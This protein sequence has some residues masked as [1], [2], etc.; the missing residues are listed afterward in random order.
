MQLCST[1]SILWHCLSLG[2][3]WKLIFSSPVA[4]AE[5]SVC[6][7]IECSTFT[8]CSFRIWNSLTGIPS[9]P[10]ALL[11]VMLPNAHL[12]SYY[13]MSGS[14]WVITSS[15]LSGSWISFF[16]RSSL[17]SWHFFLISSASFR[18]YHFCPLLSP[19]LHEIF[20]CYLQFS[21]RDL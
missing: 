11:I 16:S 18:S 21:W 3:E 10:L 8:A 9:A 19:S 5:F 13:R 7:Y 6:W 20:P 4:T 2:L 1:L 14:R 12:T 15:W 17:C